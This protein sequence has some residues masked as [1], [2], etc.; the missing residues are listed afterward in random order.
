MLIL[1]TFH[2]ETFDCIADGLTYRVYKGEL[3]RKS[4][5]IELIS[6]LY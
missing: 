3:Q 1:K 5:F 4:I 6:N 2:V